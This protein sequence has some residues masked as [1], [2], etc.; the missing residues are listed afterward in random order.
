MAKYFDLFAFIELVAMKDEQ[1]LMSMFPHRII[2]EAHVTVLTNLM[3]GKSHP[4]DQKYIGRS[5]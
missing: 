4:H 1:Q 5:V 2:Y 3:T